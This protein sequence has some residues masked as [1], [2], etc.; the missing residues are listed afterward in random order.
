MVIGAYGATRRQAAMAESGSPADRR[1][2]REWSRQTIRHKSVGVA[3]RSTTPHL[4]RRFSD[5]GTRVP[6]LRTKPLCPRQRQQALSNREI[7]NISNPFVPR[8][9]ILEGLEE[10]RCSK[11]NVS[12]PNFSLELGLR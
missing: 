8:V 4:L 3:N 12:M 2:V 6:G 10:V 9:A 5:Q 1:C 7:E 11:L